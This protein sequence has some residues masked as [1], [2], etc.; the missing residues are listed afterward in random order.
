MTESPSSSLC[1]SFPQSVAPADAVSSSACD[2]RNPSVRSQEHLDLVRARRSKAARKRAEERRADQ[3]ERQRRALLGPTENRSL[4][5]G[6]AAE[7]HVRESA[8][9]ARTLRAAAPLV[10]TA[11]C[12]KEGLVVSFSS[13]PATDGQT[14]WLGPIDFGNPMAPVFIY[15]HGFHERGHVVYTDFSLLREIGASRY[16]S[17]LFEWANVFED[18]RVDALTARD[19]AGYGLLREALFLALKEAGWSRFMPNVPGRKPSQ[20]VKLYYLAH[21]WVRELGLT[22]TA[23]DLGWLEDE[24][25]TILT[26]SEKERLD[27]LVF[28]AWPLSS[29]A[30]AVALAERV[31]ALLRSWADEVDRANREEAQA[32]PSGDPDERPFG[33]PAR[34]PSLFS[35]DFQGVSKGLSTSKRSAAE[36]VRIAR[37]LSLVNGAVPMKWAD[38]KPNEPAPF[39]TPFSEE[40]W[41]RTTEV[42]RALSL[43]NEAKRQDFRYPDVAPCHSQDARTLFS[44]AMRRLDGTAARWE[45]LFFRTVQRPVGLSESGWDI[46]DDSIDRVAVGDG[47]IFTA[48]TDARGVETAV[49]ILLDSSGSLGRSDFAIAKA[50]ACRLGLVLSKVPCLSVSLSLFPGHTGSGAEVVT[51]F[52]CPVVHFAQKTGDLESAGGTPVVSALLSTAQR[53]M[54]RSEPR[55]TLLL[56]TDGVFSRAEL[57][58]VPEDIESAGI[59]LATLLIGRREQ[60]DV[61]RICERIQGA[62]G[63]PEAIHRMLRRLQLDREVL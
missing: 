39:A 58:H 7:R 41:M 20:L 12:R 17:E 14:V 22:C 59:E 19:Y 46:D 35:D 1:S 16:G 53:L 23:G 38:P 52:D 25:F 2:E 49:A 63:L 56:I 44:E 3:L 61:G 21:L 54:V 9:G 31:L 60:E 26:Q 55:R 5:A 36:D 48:F 6:E 50:A 13:R 18:V 57:R 43:S 40:S 62:E 28:S 42:E 34:Q 33:P 24:L 4:R 10:L 30:D 27:E 37:L 32:G 51:D 47:R 29:T 8:H 15:G 11:A 45:D